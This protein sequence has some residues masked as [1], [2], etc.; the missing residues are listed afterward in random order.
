MK[1]QIQ[2]ISS[3]KENEMNINNKNLLKIVIV[4]KQNKNIIQNN[5]SSL[6]IKASKQTEVKQENKENKENTISISKKEEENK[7][8][9]ENPQNKKISLQNTLPSSC[10]NKVSNLEELILTSSTLYSQTGANIDQDKP[11]N[12]INI[13]P[14]VEYC[15]VPEREYY[16]DI[17]QELLSEEKDLIKYKQCFYINFQEELDNYKRANLIS[18]IY[19]MA[20]SFKLKNRTVFLSVQTMDRFFCEQKIDHYYFPLLCM[21]VLVI[22]SKFNEIY[23]PAYKDMIH[24]FGNGY[25]YT[26]GQALQMEELILKSINY[27]LIPIFPMCFF[28]IIAQKTNLTDTEYYLGSLMIELIQFDFCLYSVKNSIIAQTVFGK[29]MALTRDK[30]YESI[31]IL[32]GI[33]PEENFDSKSETIKLIIETLNV[34]NNLLKNVNSKYFTDIYEKYKRPEILGDS[35]NYFLKE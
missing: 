18:F 32:K 9:K 8:F 14:E 25:N 35:I 10:T 27:N 29:V 6:T 30:N 12:N 33:F 20:K 7:N 28:D 19:R 15:P 4:K 1:S 34:I 11:Y 26:V 31:K 5:I 21:C 13:F 16:D 3:K 22:S 23:Y 24:F 17:L 2:D